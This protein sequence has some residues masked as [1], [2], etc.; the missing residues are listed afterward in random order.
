MAQPPQSN[1]FTSGPILLPFIR[2]TLPILLS[3][4]LQALYSAVDLIVISRYCGAAEIAAVAAGGN[5]M[6]M[7]QVVVTGLAMGVTVAIGRYIGE[8]NFE[9][10]AKSMGS[11]ICVFAA[12]GALLTAIMLI[13]AP[14]LIRAMDMPPEAYP[15]A[16]DYLMICSAGILFLVGYNLIS[17]IFRGIGNAILP[18]VFVVIAAA[19]NVVGDIILVTQYHMGVRGVAIATVCAQAVSVVL[20][21]LI[22][23]AIKLPFQ[24]SRKHI[25]FDGEKIRE[26]FSIGTPVALKDLVTQFSFLAVNA[27]ANGMGVLLSAGY[28]IAWKVVSFV[29]LIPISFM[30]SMSAFIAQN[31]GAQ[32]PERAK[33]LLYYAWAV[34]VGIGFVVFYIVRFHS[35]ALA[36]IFTPIRM[37]LQRQQTISLTDDLDD[38][39]L[40]SGIETGQDDVEVGLLLSSGS[41]STGSGSSHGSGGN[42]ELLLQSVNQLA[43][44]QNGQA[45]DFFDHSSNFLG[46]FDKPPNCKIIF[47]DRGR[48][49][50]S[51]Y[52]AAASS[53]GAPCFSAI[54]FSTQAREEMGASMV[55]RT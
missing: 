16:V 22:I 27:I 5:V 55:P 45:L 28:G 31:M 10:A 11:S 18:L 47:L 15:F 34:A 42:A 13:A 9:D 32:Q 2:F 24:F 8:G 29:L 33:R 30:Q 1:T 46:H 25:R 3:M 14:F 26:M 44:L 7:I 17:C 12:F 36:A 48:D 39:D 51:H 54:C 35:A 4:F 6:Y 37:S 38:L 50:T 40:L 52:S 21:I 41:S 53:A 20:S 23:R 43:E 19:I 49:E